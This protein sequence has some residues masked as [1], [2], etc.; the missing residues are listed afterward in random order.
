MKNI[1][2]VTA[3]LIAGT[4]LSNAAPVAE[5]E[6]LSSDYSWTTGVDRSGRPGFTIS[7]DR[8]SCLLVN[9]NWSQAY[10]YHG[11]DT[12]LTVGAGETLKFSF[13]MLIENLDG[14]FTFTLQGE[15]LS[16]AMGKNYNNGGTFPNHGFVYAK[17]TDTSKPTSKFKD[18]DSTNVKAIKTDHKTNLDL[19]FVM[20]TKVSVSGEISAPRVAGGN[21][22][23]RLTAN[24]KTLPIPFDLEVPSFSLKKVGFYGD[25]VNNSNN[26]TFS[27]LKVSVVPEPSAFGL[28]AGLGALALVG[29]RRRRRR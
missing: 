9:S 20:N 11:F 24:D 12:P 22:T 21:Y 17:T 19:T 4:A 28:L 27:N 14:S 10:A 23:L 15:N 1:L 25:G 18:D 29:A 8:Q 16:L 7:S 13:D 2:T 6:M 26:V 3:L 5:K